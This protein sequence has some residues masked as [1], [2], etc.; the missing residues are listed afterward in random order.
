MF[1]ETEG[2]WGQPRPLQVPRWQR[3]LK[4]GEMLMCFPEEMPPLF[5]ASRA[6]KWE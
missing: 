4:A 2:N 6:L 5:A 3:A 1:N